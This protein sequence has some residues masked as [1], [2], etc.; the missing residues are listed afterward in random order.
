MSQNGQTHFKNLSANAARF[1][2]C[3]HFGTLHIK[4]LKAVIAGNSLISAGL[5]IDRILHFVFYHKILQIYQQHKVWKY[6]RHI[7]SKI[8]TNTHTPLG[9]PL[10]MSHFTPR[11][12]QKTY[13][14]SG[15]IEMWH[16]TK[17]VKGT[18]LSR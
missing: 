12:R 1:L 16:R 7:L 10:P 14:F 15:C 8:P 18:A 3:D 9:T 6:Y 13:G 4:G 5:D 2:K 11:K 17:S